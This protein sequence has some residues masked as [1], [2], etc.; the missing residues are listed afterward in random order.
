MSTEQ[1]TIQDTTTGNGFSPEAFRPN[2]ALPAAAPASTQV[3]S[4][5]SESRRKFSNDYKLKILADYE[6]CDKPLARGELLRK[7]G[8]Y[9][10]RLTY[11]GNNAIPAGLP[12]H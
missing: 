6:A 11:G 2:S 8:L 3:D 4:K 5:Q 10:S 1:K 7:E 12:Y 9:H